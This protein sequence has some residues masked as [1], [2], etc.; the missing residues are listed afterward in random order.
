MAERVKP[1]RASKHERRK[2]G[3]AGSLHHRILE[4]CERLGLVLVA[5]DPLP[6]MVGVAL[7]FDDG[8]HCLT[9]ITIEDSLRPEEWDRR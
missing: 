4:L 7:L 6:N 8:E 9:E 1:P 3:V 2:V 5:V